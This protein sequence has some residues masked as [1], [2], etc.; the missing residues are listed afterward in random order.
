[1]FWGVFSL[2]GFIAAFLLPIFVYL[3]GIAYPLHLWPVG[4]T[5]PTRL[6]VGRR[7]GILFIFVVI[8][9]S[10]FHGVFR[11]T[12][13]ISDLGLKRYVRVLEILGYVVIAI[14]LILLIYY[15]LALHSSFFQI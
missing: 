14:G 3:V 2:G 12:S 15:L 10:L 4:T 1:L 8:G 11:F 5:D 13:A 6:F 9:G 7:L